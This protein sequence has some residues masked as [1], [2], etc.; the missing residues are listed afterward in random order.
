[1]AT[2]NWY[3]NPGMDGSF[4]V[5]P[6]QSS[7]N[8]ITSGSLV[9]ALR[10]G[11]GSSPSAA[12]N[13]TGNFAAPF[14]R[15]KS[16]DPLVKVTD[17]THSINVRI[18][19]GAVIET[20][21][22]SVDQSIGGLDESQP[23]LVWSISG[24]TCNTGPVAA[25]GSVITGT[26]G[27]CVMDGAGL[28][29]VDA[30]TGNAGNA[31]SFGGITSYELAQFAANPA[32]FPQHMLAY[33]LDPNYQCSG[34]G[35]I[36]PLQLVDNS[37]ANTGPIPQGCTIGIPASTTM[38]S[39]L[40]AAQQ[41]WFNQLQ[42]F[43]AFFY[44]V[45]AS[46]Y[47]TFFIYDDTGGTY[48]TQVSQ[49]ANAISSVMQY[50]CIL[51]YASGTS[52]AQYSLATTKGATSTST[53]AFPAPAPLDLSPTGGV[54]VSPSTFGAWYPSGYNATPTNTVQSS[55]SQTI[56]GLSA[57][58]TYDFQVYAFNASGNG[59][60][61]SPQVVATTAGTVSGPAPATVAQ[62]IAGM[63]VNTHMAQGYGSPYTTMLAYLGIN[64]LRDGEV[65]LA[66]MQT[67]PAGTKLCMNIGNDVTNGSALAATL[68]NA[69]Y[70]LAV[71][72]PNE[73]NNFPITYNGV[74][75]GGSTGT[76]TPV[77]Q[78]QAA[79]Y[80][81]VKGNSAT[82]GYPVFNVSETGA[83]SNN[84]GL[85]WCQIPTGSGIVMPD[86]TTYATHCNVHNYVC[87][88]QDVYIDNMAWNAA[89][90]LN[91]G[92]IDGFY[93]N[94]VHTWGYGYNGY[95]AAQALA[96]AKVTTETGWDTTSNPGGVTVQGKV[97]VNTYLAQFARGWA[98]TFI[99]EMVDEEGSSG[100]QGLYTTAFVAKDSA[101][102]IHN[103]TTILNN[104][105]ATGFTPSA[106]TYS[107][108]SEPTTVHDLL[109]QKNTTTYDLCIWGESAAGTVSTVTVNLGA[110]VTTL[111]V[112]DVTTGTASTQTLTNVSTVS[113]PVSDHALILE[114]V[115]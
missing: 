41:F 20:P 62:F 29:M 97:L 76:W 6:F 4:W 54:N 53:N 115:V 44:N 89:S 75:G 66:K 16:T 92:G 38:P 107:I 33:S 110:V 9:T 98:Y 71:E 32:Y 15:G 36:W 69:G 103:M 12:I 102:Y 17:G 49:L 18:P 81:A 94:C 50:V 57:G 48:S 24:A 80:A 39:N 10:N 59:P 2:R 78:C 73:P 61:S 114:F 43:G 14:Y 11:Y 82:V 83:E 101:T 85:Q 84:V 86:G 113:V 47:T 67:F 79:I 1:M 60:V 28:L 106:F 100:F 72:G 112:Y 88:T 99:Y 87:G 34:V 70:L 95:T 23:Y 37:S 93:G 26:Y 5:Q 25:S 105:I 74:E 27:F 68:A 91:V 109:L 19:L 45:A 22:S 55:Y 77:A 96:I 65:S 64:N 31:N 63:G 104:G 40:T 46:G 52:G 13:V 8:W 58:T 108:P 21:A 56:T 30:V 42:Q 51:N 111:N 90:T 35:P 3:D 7:A